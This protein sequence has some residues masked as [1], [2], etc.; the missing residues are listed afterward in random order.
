MRTDHLQW[1]A[2]LKTIIAHCRVCFQELCLIGLGNWQNLFSKTCCNIMYLFKCNLWGK[3]SNAFYI[4]YTLLYE[5]TTQGK[6]YPNSIITENAMILCC[7]GQFLLASRVLVKAH[8]M[9]F[10]FKVFIYFGVKSKQ[11]ENA[12]YF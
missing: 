4:V 3:Y 9:G 5:Q 11:K 12:F 7:I 6:V 2:K 1:S 8:S 10:T